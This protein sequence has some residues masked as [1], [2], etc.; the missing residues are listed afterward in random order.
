MN[1]LYEGFKA[2]CRT[3]DRRP[4]WQWCEEHVVV[5]AT[6]P[7]PGRWR[8]DNSPWVRE[9]MECFQDNR[10]S[11][12]TVLCAAQSAKT[13]TLMN[14][15]C[16]AIAE[17]PGPAL[18]VTAARDEAGQFIADRFY[19]TLTSCA[20]V[21]DLLISFHP[22]EFHFP[23]MPFYFVGA[24]SKSKLQ[25]KPQRWLFCDEVRNYPPGALEMVL[26]RTRAYWNARRVMLSTPDRT[27]DAVDR[28]YR[29]GDQRVWHMQC[30]RCHALHPLDFK[31]IKWD[32]NDITKPDGR[33][34]MDALALTIRLECPSCGH[35]IRDTPTERR[36]IAK[37]GQFVALNPR[38]PKH[39]VS[40]HWNALLPP[41]VQWRSV[42]EEFLNAR[43][44]A[45]SGD[46]V[47]LKTFVNET[48]G[49]SWDD[50]LGVIDDF[51][52]LEQRREDYEFAGT[53]SEEIVRFIAADRQEKGGEHYFWLVR[54]F[55]LGGRSRLVSHGRC[56]SLLELDEV[57]RQYGVSA[58][59]SVIDSGW[60]ANE[61]YRF[62]A[63]TGWKAMKG[64][65]AE[66]FLAKSETDSKTVRQLWQLTWARPEG[67]R[68]ARSMRKVRLFRWSN[69][70]VKDLLAEYM[71]GLTGGWTIPGKVESEYVRQIT[72]EQRDEY[73][74]GLGRTR[75]RWVQK[76]KDNHYFDCELMITA[77]AVIT[78]RITPVK[79][80]RKPPIGALTP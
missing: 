20:P 42:V 11:D 62:C 64:D 39:K 68:A 60:K 10:V 24:G 19:P 53:W 26:K 6:S 69:P 14:C 33:W 71:Q 77:A 37:A 22:L 54:A 15:A 59:N 66:Y 47:A 3:P 9:I 35:A 52:F 18:W 44:S 31:L 65:D 23:G 51:G 41:W 27:G 29:A 76:R 40:F 61:I 16:W 74:D 58:V 38:A 79:G 13:Q 45:K 63:A 1:P 28:S 50:E 17:D 73:T 49:E 46:L 21:N 75:F 2:A 34:D 72:A 25:S 48:L 30:P 36:I 32:S 80:G 57:R 12:I 5:D 4:V 78:K 7:M 67:V 55:G 70:W 43:I 8:S 56:N